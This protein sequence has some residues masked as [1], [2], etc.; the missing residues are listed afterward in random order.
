MRISPTLLDR[1]PAIRLS[2]PREELGDPGAAGLGDRELEVREALEHAA[3]D[4]VGQRALRVERDLQ[5]VH[6]RHGRGLLVDG[7]AGAA[8]G[9][10]DDLVLLAERPQ[11]VV[12]GVVERL[13]PVAGGGHRAD[14]DAA[15]Q[16]VVVDP[17]GVGDGVVDVVE[18]DL[19][20]AGAGLG[21]LA[22]RSRRASGCGPGCRRD[23]ARTRRAWGAGRTARSS[24]RTAGTVFGKMTSPTTPS[25]CWSVSRRSLSQLRMRS[26]VSFRSLNG[27]LYFV[28]A[29]RRSRPCTR[30]RGTRGTGRGC[31]R[32]GCRRRSRCSGRQV[33][34]SV[35]P[36][37]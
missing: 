12:D 2:R 31:H 24:G 3:E 11:R 29:R 33:R 1:M 6:Q 25:P 30:R 26:S 28:R 10:D 7:P 5:E 9:V 15:A 27:F 32:R 23:G 34:A 18:E 21:L 8:V 36:Q 19:A 4:H 22:A 14:E 17:L 20:D 13:D 35:P 16:A 37:G